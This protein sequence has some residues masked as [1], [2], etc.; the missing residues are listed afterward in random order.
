MLTLE[1]NLKEPSL[2]VITLDRSFTIYDEDVLDYKIWTR[3][4]NSG[5]SHTFNCGQDKKAKISSD[6]E[7]FIFHL[8]VVNFNKSSF[9]MQKDKSLPVFKAMIEKLRNHETEEIKR[10]IKNMQLL[11]T[12]GARMTSTDD[13]FLCIHHNDRPADTVNIE[14]MKEFF[15]GKITK[16]GRTEFFF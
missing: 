5:T 1:L 7:N 9:T 6:A 14:L 11:L 16:D 12:R 4:I 8:E 15:E 10:S 3:I 2:K 13:K